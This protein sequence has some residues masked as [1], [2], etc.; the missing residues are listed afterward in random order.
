MRA[1]FGYW[2]GIASGF[3]TT[4]VGMVAAIRHVGRKEYT[5]EYPERRD[6][7]PPRARMSLF[8]NADECI[9]CAQCARA[10]PVN[11]ITVAS[12]KRPKDEE[13]PVTVVGQRKKVLVLTEYKIDVGRCC[14]CGLCVE[15]CPTHSLYMTPYFEM[16]VV[17]KAAEPDEILHEGESFAAADA[18]RTRSEIQVQHPRFGRTGLVYDFLAITDDLRRRGETV[19]VNPLFPEEHAQLVQNR[20]RPPNQDAAGTTDPP[21]GRN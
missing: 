21:G 3:M 18:R 9:A 14:F 7:L 20:V 4:L 5:L 16:A 8:M 2:R 6:V 17:Q 13:P 1:F 19:P 15:P 11:C 12:V 10:C